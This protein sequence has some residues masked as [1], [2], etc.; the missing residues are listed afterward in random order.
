MNHTYI[1]FCI[2]MSTTAHAPYK[3]FA[4]LLI[5]IDFIWLMVWFSTLMWFESQSPNFVPYRD[6]LRDAFRHHVCTL[7]LIYYVSSPKPTI[8]LLGLFPFIYAVLD[9]FANVLDVTRRM[10]ATESVVAWNMCVALLSIALIV[11]VCGFIWYIVFW[12]NF[13][14]K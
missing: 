8:R 3:Q 13:K 2:K 11:S 12:F 9:D 4:L 7:A 14:K 10:D 1:L 6:E 5:T